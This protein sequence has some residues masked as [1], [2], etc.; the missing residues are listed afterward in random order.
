MRGASLIALV[1]VA[2][3]VGMPSNMA[4]AAS[5][6]STAT[7]DPEETA[8]AQEAAQF[9]RTFGLDAA[10]E[11]VRDAAVDTA[12]YSTWPYGVPLSKAEIAEMGRRSQVQKAVARLVPHALTLPGY[13]GVYLDQLAGGQPVFLFTDTLAG[14]SRD[15]I[16]GLLPAGTSF[17]VQAA[18]RTENELLEQQQRI[19]AELPA[20]WASGIDVVR[21]AVKTSQN[22]LRIGVRD[23]AESER[24]ELLA[25]YGAD[26]DV[27][28]DGM[29]QSDACPATNDCRPIKGGISINH[30]GGS[31][32]ECT[33]GFIVRGSNGSLY[34]L[35]AGHCIETTGGYDI[36]WRH[37]NDGFGRARRETW[38]PG[39]TGSADVGL[40]TIDSSEQSLMTNKNEMR[41]T[42]NSVVTVI[43]VD[44]IAPGIEGSQAC[45][46]GRTSG[47]DCGVV[48]E[49]KVGRASKVSGYSQMWV[50][51]STT[52][53]F[54]SLGGD[55]GGPVFYY[56]NG[57]TT[58]P[59]AVLGTHVHSE[60][61]SGAN[62][63]WFSGFFEGSSN[64]N[65]LWG[66][67]YWP[68][69]DAACS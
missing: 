3:G 45:R 10:P 27:F 31:A 12:T 60:E 19:E 6:T 23:L 8:T 18:S 57:G 55:S 58:G 64:Y 43:G 34:M 14:T 36:V 16:G 20:I 66:I 65:A 61:G 1:M 46:V 13:A 5:Q 47:H 25:R 9:R 2:M 38:I 48:S 15:E 22:R 26:L 49:W 29:A 40:I 42:N 41:R 35:T 68:C 4:T 51:D 54:D 37:N 33:S 62:E 63:G 30:A 50:T 69:M 11:L 59:V 7:P 52:V 32:G 28:E 21:V 67:S 17:R 53:N 24:Q 39:G 56:D 44:L